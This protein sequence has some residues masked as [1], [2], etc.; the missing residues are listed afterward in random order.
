MPAK[1]TNMHWIERELE[2]PLVSFIFRVHPLVV[3]K[4]GFE[5]G[6]TG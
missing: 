1:K 4:I 6:G 3:E 2:R 5:V